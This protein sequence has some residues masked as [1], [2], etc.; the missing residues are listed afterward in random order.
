VVVTTRAV[1]PAPAVVTRAVPPA[2]VL[3]TLAPTPGAVP[4]L[5]VTLA[6]VLLAAMLAL[7]VTPALAAPPTWVLRVLVWM[8]PSLAVSTGRPGT[9]PIPSG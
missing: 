8:L 2:P 1:L 3:V 5:P 4:A 9:L 6:P 7:V